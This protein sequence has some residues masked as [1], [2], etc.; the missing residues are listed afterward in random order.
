MFATLGFPRTHG[1]A[2][3]SCRAA[4]SHNVIAVKSCPPFSPESDTAGC[5]SNM[6]S[7]VVDP[8]RPPSEATKSQRCLQGSHLVGS[9]PSL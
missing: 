1:P 9:E 3:K 6:S 4:W 7:T 5:W 8:V 2:V